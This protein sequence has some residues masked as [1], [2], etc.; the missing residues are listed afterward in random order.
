LIL[1]QRRRRGRRRR[2]KR[3]RRRREWRQCSYCQHAA[4]TVASSLYFPLPAS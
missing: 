4:S 3:R 1:W 2:R